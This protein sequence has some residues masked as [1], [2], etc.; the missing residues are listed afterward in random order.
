MAKTLG[1]DYCGYK[2]VKDDD[3]HLPDLYGDKTVNW[4]DLLENEYLVITDQDGNDVDIYK[5]QDGKHRTI[6]RKAVESIALGKVKPKNFQQKCAIDALLDERSTVKVLT[7]SFGSGKTMLA[8]LCAF[9]MIQAGQ[10]DKIVWIRNPIGVKDV[11]EIGYL[12]GDL[13]TKLLPFVM[14]LCDHVGGSDALELYIQQGKIEV[15]HLAHIRGRDIRNSIIFC[16]EAE[17]LTRSQV[18]L[19]LG[20]VAEG[21][22]IIFEGDFKQVDARTFE[23][24]N[25]GM[26]AAIDCLRGNKLFAYVNMPESVRSETAKLADLLDLE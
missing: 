25:N 1:V 8:C 15:I 7:G 13:Q 3:S 14:P 19:L 4:Y 9:Q 11:T 6:Y 21:T 24:E 23:S 17:N 22:T 2:V 16:S 5:W 26:K 10:S 12:K 20:R 18:Q